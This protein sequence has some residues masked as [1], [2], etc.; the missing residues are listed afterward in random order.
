[1]HAI[2]LPGLGNVHSHAFQRGMAGLAEHR[3][4]QADDFWTWREAMYRFLD[5]LEPDHVAAIAEQ[6]EAYVVAG[7]PLPERSQCSSLA[8][9]AACSQGFCREAVPGCGAGCTPEEG[10]C[11]GSAGCDGCPYVWEDFQNKPC[12][13]P[14]K[15][16]WQGGERE[17]L[18]IGDG[19]AGSEHWLIADLL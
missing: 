8:Y 12:S 5:R 13:L 14:N 7:C 6:C 16:C 3:G 17:L 18:C 10:I 11:K 15:I 9:V 1:M 19:D 4:P 2:A